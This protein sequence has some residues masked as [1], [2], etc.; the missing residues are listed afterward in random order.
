[1][2]SWRSDR[3]ISSNY[4]AERGGLFHE[5]Q[6]EEPGTTLFQYNPFVPQELPHFI[7]QQIQV[8]LICCYISFGKLK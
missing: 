3:I 8:N 2:G 5:P 6:S 1:M 7:P 4:I